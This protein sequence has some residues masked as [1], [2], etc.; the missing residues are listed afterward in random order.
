MD[1]DEHSAA[2]P[3]PLSLLH[4]MEE[5]AGEGRCPRTKRIIVSLPLTSAL[6]P[7]GTGGEREKL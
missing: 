1:T 5:R 3:L 2:K 7:R 6:S 4:R